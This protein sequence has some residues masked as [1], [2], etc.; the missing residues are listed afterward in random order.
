M[1]N[2]QIVTPQ[3]LTSRLEH[4]SLSIDL[5]S[6]EW[7]AVEPGVYMKA[8]YKDEASGESTILIEIGSRDMLAHAFS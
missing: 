8:I 3:A 4:G 1:W 5:N 7:T 6:V 2:G